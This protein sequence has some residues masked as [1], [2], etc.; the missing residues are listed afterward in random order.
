MLA[1]RTL[2]WVVSPAL[3][4]EMKIS[5]ITRKEVVRDYGESNLLERDVRAVIC[6]AAH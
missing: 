1:F 2:I 6:E 3:K 4:N 5:N